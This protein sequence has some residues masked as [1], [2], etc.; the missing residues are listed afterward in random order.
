MDLT[1]VNTIRQQLFA[2]GRMKV[3]S[4]GAH[5]WAAVDQF[6]LRFKVQGRN[7]KGYVRVKLNAMDTYD[8]EFIKINRKKND[9]GGFDQEP[10]TVETK[11]GIYCDQLTDV[12]DRF[13]EYIPE[14]GD[15]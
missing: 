11:E 8:I 2:G 4:W 3:F 7:F 15:R 5:A 6:T 9:M 13:V 10:E 12:I 14:Y 1:V